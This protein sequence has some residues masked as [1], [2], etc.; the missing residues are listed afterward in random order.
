MVRSEFAKKQFVI[1][2]VRCLFVA[3]CVDG[4]HETGQNFKIYVCVHFMKFV[5]RFIG[6][7]M[8]L[9]DRL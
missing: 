3:V 5:W 8:Y 1:N 4:V 2:C 6:L 7:K 9:F